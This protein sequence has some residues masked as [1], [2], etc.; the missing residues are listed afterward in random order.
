MYRPGLGNVI[1]DLEIPLDM[2]A[3][4]PAESARVIAQTEA[5]VYE[6]AW[7]AG[8]R[9]F[10]ATGQLEQY[11]TWIIGGAALVLVLAFMKRR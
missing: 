5:P 7:A 4:W 8:A 1:T 3:L 2:R 9:Q 6:Q 10:S 11:K